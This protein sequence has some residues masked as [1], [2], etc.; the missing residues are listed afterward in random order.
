MIKDNKGNHLRKSSSGVKRKSGFNPSRVHIE[1]A[2][3]HIQEDDG[4]DEKLLYK[5]IQRMD[6]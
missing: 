4:K 1:V 2:E 3:S 6:F 5:Y